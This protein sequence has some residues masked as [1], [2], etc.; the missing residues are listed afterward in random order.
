MKSIRCLQH[1]PGNSAGF[2]GSEENNQFCVVLSRM[3]SLGRSLPGSLTKSP[4]S[5][6]MLRA[7]IQGQ[8]VILGQ[9]TV[10]NRDFSFL[11][12]SL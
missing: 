10:E 9:V 5:L 2:L 11:G 12:P 8:G 1:H 6:F 7:Y 4:S 3:F